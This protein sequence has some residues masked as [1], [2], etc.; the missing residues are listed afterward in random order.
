MVYQLISTL[1]SVVGCDIGE[2]RFSMPPLSSPPTPASHCMSWSHWPAC[3]VVVLY[4]NPSTRYDTSPWQWFM[5]PSSR[6]G[7]SRQWHGEP[8]GMTASYSLASFMPTPALQK[9]GNSS[10]L[11]SALFHSTLS[12]KVFYHFRHTWTPTFATSSG[13]V[14]W[15]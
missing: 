4:G 2:S 5:W 6:H 10:S 14:L 12:I 9:F 7:C 11:S 13:L 8:G 1:R 15:L 3:P